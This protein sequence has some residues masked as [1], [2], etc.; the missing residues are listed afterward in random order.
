MFSFKIDATAFLKS[1]KDAR[2]KLAKSIMIVVRRAAELAASHARNTTL[3]KDKTG[4]L[5]RSIETHYIDKYHAQAQA[6][7]RHAEWV[8][9]GNGFRTGAEFIYPKR[10]PFLVFEVD[11]RKILARRVRTTTPMPFMEQARK[12]VEPHFVQ[13]C[14]DAVSNMF[15]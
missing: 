5:R 9:R 6:T 15:G 2:K 12:Y 14:R 13:A 8:E 10:A 4:E 1:M 3:F 11:N 7:A